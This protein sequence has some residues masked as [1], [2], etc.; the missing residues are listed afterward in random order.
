[1]KLIVWGEREKENENE[2]AHKHEIE[3]FHSIWMAPLRVNTSTVEQLDFIA[4]VSVARKYLL[5]CYRSTFCIF[6]GEFFCIT[7][8]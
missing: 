8:L 4:P 6:C 3:C 1:M 7:A 5:T 2:C